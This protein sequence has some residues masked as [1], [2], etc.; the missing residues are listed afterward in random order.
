MGTMITIIKTIMFLF[1]FVKE[2]FLSKDKRGYDRRRRPSPKITVVKKIF[3]LLVCFSLVLN[4]YLIV[5]VFDLGRKTL[6]LNKRIKE[7]ENKPVIYP[8]SEEKPRDKP[9][10]DPI[11][12]PV[13]EAPVEKKNKT[14]PIS[15]KRTSDPEDDLLKN[16][17]EIDKIR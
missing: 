6:E 12:D 17:E 15:K 1:P 3:I 2:M 9:P 11:P 13:V 4:Y 14:K 16:L 5:K 7:E 10:P 8:K